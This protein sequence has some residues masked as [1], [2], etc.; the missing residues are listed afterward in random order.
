MA[1]EAYL[2]RKH[3]EEMGIIEPIT[4]KRCRHCRQT[5]ARSDFPASTIVSDGVSSWCRS[6]HAEANVRWRAKRNASRPPGV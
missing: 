6:C 5:K 3:R 2:R 4:E 1:T